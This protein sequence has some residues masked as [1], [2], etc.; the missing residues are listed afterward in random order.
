MVPPAQAQEALKSL[1]PVP[2]PAAAALAPRALADLNRMIT[3]GDAYFDLSQGVACKVDVAQRQKEADKWAAAAS[4]AV[5]TT[6]KEAAQSMISGACPDGD[7]VFSGPVEY[8]EASLSRTEMSN[9]VMDTHTALRIQG[10][11]VQGRAVGESTSFTRNRSTTYHKLASGELVA[12]QGA[13][14]Q[15][16]SYFLTYATDDQSGKTIKP[17]VMFSF[18]AARKIVVVNVT[19]SPDGVREVSTMYTDGKLFM[20]TRSKNGNYHGLTEYFDP[21]LVQINKDKVCYQNGTEIKALQCP[22]T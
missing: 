14:A 19:E 13:A 20:R 8:V 3:Q 2:D 16:V 22:D 12:P 21:T 10:V 9:I 15:D 17:R 1:G 5:M 6:I 18:D 4:G 7:G 11:Q